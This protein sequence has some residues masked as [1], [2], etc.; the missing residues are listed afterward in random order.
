MALASW[1]VPL[2]SVLDTAGLGFFKPM[3]FA[4]SAIAAIMSPLFFGAMA[5]RSV[6]PAKVLRW[7]SVSTAATI[8]LIAWAIENN[9]S[10]WTILLMIQVQALFC[11]PTSS[12]AGSIVFSQ[13]VE[14]KRQYG[15]I[16][17]LGTIG[18]IAGCWTVSMIGLD[19]S[20]KAFYISGFLWLLLA[21]FTL[22]L[23]HLSS[24]CLSSHRLT[25]RE[26]FGWD[27]LSLL[28]NPD[29]RVVFITPALVAI[30]F[31]AFYPFTPPHLAN[32]G[33]NRISAWMSLGQVSEVIALICIGGI[34]Q[35]WTFKGVVCA[36]MVFGVLRYLLYATNSTVWVLM[37]LALH[38]AAFTFTYVSTQIYLAEN[39]EATWRTR[40]QAL[41]SLM[42]GG[43][44]NL[45]GY[46]FCG[47]WMAMCTVEDF[48]QWGQYW[49]GLSALVMM[50]LVYFF[51]SYPGK[52]RVEV[53]IP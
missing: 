5:D 43:L 38:G 51:T 39:I 10:G 8:C 15:T 14:S 7:I 41:L 50:V 20:P 21:M 28:R 36:G 19:S 47:A 49:G 53:R 32:L 24:L 6:P 30:P 40:A 33:L 27:A 16:R 44:G 22:R 46:L 17:S 26:R 42:T 34:L 18:W 3:A 4:S 25:L 52:C 29:H 9:M 1:F 45:A 37:G 23:P 31:A 11:S 48:V 12:L 2:G 35:R 13:L